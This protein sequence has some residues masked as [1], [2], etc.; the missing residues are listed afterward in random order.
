VTDWIVA[1]ARER[2]WRS[3][4]LVLGVGFVLGLV[5]AGGVLLWLKSGHPG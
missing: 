5:I 2:A 4:L 1:G 3:V